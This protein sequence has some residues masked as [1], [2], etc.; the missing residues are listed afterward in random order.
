MIQDI[1]ERYIEKNNL[2]RTEGQKGFENLVQIVTTLGY[3]DP[4]RYGSLPNGCYVGNLID[5]LQDNPGAIDALI[6][7]IGE[8]RAPEW[9]ELL[10]DEVGPPEE[11]EEEEEETT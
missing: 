8:Q 9:E 10:L 1:L 3:K 6:M 11:E 5:F 4:M 7:W 2:G